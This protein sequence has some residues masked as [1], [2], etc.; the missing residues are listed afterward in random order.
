[1]Q[2]WLAEKKNN[3]STLFEFEIDGTKWKGT[4]DKEMKM[5]MQCLKKKIIIA[6]IEYK[7]TAP[8]YVFFI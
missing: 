5:V 6:F 1:M 8:K 4:I 2:K 3:F 7:I